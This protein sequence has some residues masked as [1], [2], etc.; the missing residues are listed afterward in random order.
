[1][2]RGAFRPV[3]M[4]GVD[5]SRPSVDDVAAA[6]MNA[7]SG[8]DLPVFLVPSPSWVI[9]MGS[10][11]RRDECRFVGLRLNGLRSFLVAA[12]IGGSVVGIWQIP[13][14]QGAMHGGHARGVAG[15]ADTPAVAVAAPDA[16]SSDTAKPAGWLTV[17]PGD[18]FVIIG[19]TLAER[20]QHDGYFETA[21]QSRFPDHRLTVR[22]LGWSADEIDLRPRSANF[23]DHGHRLVDHAPNVVLAMFGLNESFAGPS[24]LESF[25]TRFEKFLTGTRDQL[26]PSAQLVICSP[27]PHENLGQAE[28]PDGSATNAN[29]RLYMEA[30]KSAS[31]AAGV[32]FV[33]LFSPLQAAMAASTRPLTINGIH[34]NRRGNEVLGRVLDVS[35]FGPKPK[36]APIDSAA[37]RA[38]V[39]E[40]NRQFFFDY[41]AVNGYYIYGGRKNPYGVVNFPEEFAKLRKMIAVRDQRIWDIAQG[42]PVPDEIDDSSTGELSPIESNYSADIVYLSPEESLQKFKLTDG[43]EIELVVSELDFPEMVN[44]VALDID[45]RGRLWVTTNPSYPQYLPGTP[46]DDK[47][48]IYED[49]NGDGRADKQTVFADKLHL[50]IGIALGDG[51]AYVSQQPDLMFLKDTNGDG[52]C[53]TRERVLHGF[54][55]ADSHHAL[56][57]FVFGPD[58]ALYFQEGTFHFSQVE[59][60]RGPQRVRDAAVFRYE[61]R[62]AKFEI[63]VSY[64]F[65]NPWGHCFDR[66]GQNFVADASPGS[67]YFA[68]PFSGDVIYPHKHRQMQQFLVKQ[69]RPTAACLIVGNRHF[70]ET[71][72]GNYL[73]NNTI[74]FLGTL[75]YR[76]TDEG[77]GFKG[78]PVEPLVSSSDTNYRP[79]DMKFGPDGALYIVDWF[80]PLIGH[81]QHNLRDPNRDKQHGR[82]WRVRHK[83][84]PLA[85]IPEIEGAPLDH[86]VS[87]LEQYDNT[88]RHLAR[89]ELRTRDTAEVVAAIDA[90]LA[91]QEG[92]SEATEHRRLEALWVMQ[93]HDRVRPELLRQVLDSQDYRARAAATRVLSYW[94]DRIP[95]ATEWLVALAGDEAARVRLE[96]VR[97]ASFYLDADE[98]RRVV[99][100]ALEHPL[101]DYLNYVIN[102]TNTTLDRRGPSRATGDDRLILQVVSGEVADSQIVSQV[103]AALAGAN[104]TQ[105]GQLADAVLR[106]EYSDGNRATAITDL[107]V[108]AQ[109]KRLQSTFDVDT[110]VRRLEDARR[111]GRADVIVGIAR[112]AGAWEIKEL[113]FP[114]RDAARDPATPGEAV[115]AALA[116]IVRFNT[117]SAGDTR[118]QFLRDDLSPEL[119]LRFAGAVAPVSVP[120]ATRA[121]AMAIESGIGSRQA[122]PL[123]QATRAILADANGLRQLTSALQPIDPDADTAK[124]LLRAL[125]AAE[126]RIGPLVERLSEIAGIGG[127]SEPLTPEQRQAMV[128]RIE[129]E[130]DPAQ[131]QWVYRR[132]ELNCIQCHAISNAGGN[133]GPDLSGIG[134]NSPTE[135]LLESILEPSAAIKEAYLTRQVLTADGIV[136]RGVQVDRD[137]RRLILRDENGREI[138][139][140]IDDIEDESEGK[141]LMPEGQH[142]LL[143]EDELIDLVAFLAALGKPGEYAVQTRPTINRVDTLAEAPVDFAWDRRPGELVKALDELPVTA[144]QPAY[145]LINGVLP[146]ESLSAAARQ[147]DRSAPLVLRGHV[148]IGVAGPLAVK[149]IGPQRVR[150]ILGDREVEP[151]AVSDWPVGRQAVQVIVPAG[152]A[153]ESVLIEVVK[154]AGSTAQFTIVGGS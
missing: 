125:F 147:S 65:A 81:M 112:L 13:G 122:D 80:N 128:R 133:V 79:I 31:D 11:C 5:A 131:G 66:W 85:E 6:F 124:L 130:G 113:I 22:N 95:E 27:I 64:N 102:E 152:E 98:G 109:S 104:A 67:N 1:M 83:D 94:R 106:G 18:K 146:A 57:A 101:D 34:L 111:R 123:V 82:I 14:W 48:L 96:A 54:D 129:T 2:R 150:L 12:L 120:Q 137:D 121:L 55:S 138:V 47:V 110:A 26:D 77:S 126:V 62:T 86:L 52:I 115:D 43:F 8:P 151:G 24:G 38:A 148:D 7:K 134:V 33:D 149:V 142:H 4:P 9:S 136:L 97:A 49:T 144:W 53:D 84:Q 99:A 114:L 118:G 50:P 3:A 91:R 72:Q 37:V 25:R 93:Q 42:K 145:A 78:S 90:W 10:V 143:T 88:I 107:V 70:P 135:Y 117:P 20:M 132:Q 19:N 73:I 74:G 46:P 87:L 139:V 61:P 63:F 23:D 100:M 105:L 60:P 116:A 56:S 154:P 68:A 89:M 41:R 58:G 153:V 44:P 141:S 45:A 35:L 17:S 40:K 92:D 75:N 69:W 127:P 36:S 30:M 32:R 51:G 76:M 71:L 108:A 15:A 59:T 16:A 119:R 39:V 29:V 140:P 103:R 21:L 28:L